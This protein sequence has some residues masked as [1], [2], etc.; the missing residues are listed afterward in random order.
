MADVWIYAI[1]FTVAIALFFGTKWAAA[2][3]GGANASVAREAFTHLN[4]FKPGPVYAYMGSA[5][6]YDGTRNRIAIW[7]KASGARVV[8]PDRV[9]E[10]HAGVLLT[11]V[12]HRTTAT[13]MIQLYATASTKPFFKVGV[14][15]KRDC[16]EWAVILRAAFGAEKER[17]VDVRVLGL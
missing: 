16:A 6:G 10:W 11:Q 2:T 12:F 3:F 8:S 5:I 15:R 7:E 13:P 9:S 1:T 14:V 4:G 17:D